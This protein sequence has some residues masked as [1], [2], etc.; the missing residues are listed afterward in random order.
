M[1]QASKEQ[2]TTQGKATSDQQ[3]TR[4]ESDSA[5]D[6][7]PV[8][9]PPTS[10][11][12]RV[13]DYDELDKKTVDTLVDSLKYIATSSGIVI[14]MYSQ[15]LRDYVKLPVIATRP[16]AQM[17]VF[18]P[19]LLWF[20]AIL[21]TVIGIF[22]R[23][24]GAVTDAE[25]EAAMRDLRRRKIFWVRLVLLPFMLGFALF[26]YIIAAQIWVVYPFR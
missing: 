16:L 10:P 1:T 22:P 12:P 21:G 17:F 5:S 25:K 24:Y 7:I 14:A 20:M 13:T 11:P 9:R 3:L 26:L 8:G 19:L 23:E 18:A 2:S 15:A 4:P 6:R